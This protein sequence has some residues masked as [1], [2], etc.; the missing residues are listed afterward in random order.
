MKKKNN[1]PV[2]YY[3]RSISPGHMLVVMEKG[4][5]SFEVPLGWIDRKTDIGIS[6]YDRQPPDNDC[7]FEVSMI[8]HPMFPIRDLP[9]WKVLH[10]SPNLQ[11]KGLSR[12][13]IVEETRPG[14]QI[15]HLHYRAMH[16]TDN[17]LAIFCTCMIRALEFHVLMSY[18]Y[19][20]EESE[21]LAPVWTRAIETFQIGI[22]VEGG[23][24]V[25]NPN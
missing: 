19:W 10:D 12:E 1:R 3:K 8:R 5:I 24:P 14:I 2:P 17:R 22:P 7:I 15:A 4:L 11:G 18:A 13:D 23:A 21:R 6:L 20:P 25:P 9:L 16:P